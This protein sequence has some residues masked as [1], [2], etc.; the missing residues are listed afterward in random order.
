MLRGHPLCLLVISLKE[1]DEGNHEFGVEEDDKFVLAIASAFG[2]GCI[3]NNNEDDAVDGGE[4][5][6]VLQYVSYKRGGV[7]AFHEV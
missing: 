3:N 5:Y 1:R 6:A 2:M 4:Y 7:E